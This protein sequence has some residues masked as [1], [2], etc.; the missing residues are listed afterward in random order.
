MSGE[1]KSDA[2]RVNNPPPPLEALA[3][4]GDA[5]ARMLGISKSQLHNLRRSGR[6][7]PEPIRL[8]R[9]CRFRVAEL[10]AWVNHGCPP[11]A[12][13]RA[14]KNSPGRSPA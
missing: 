2:M 1:L 10:V 7:G 3:V 14:L 5:T 13:W 4:D 11:R 12:Q 9:C 8:G 6:F